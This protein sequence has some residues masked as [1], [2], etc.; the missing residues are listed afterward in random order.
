MTLKYYRNYDSVVYLDFSFHL[1]ANVDL[2]MT[3]VW[4]NPG[5]GPA[6][7]QDRT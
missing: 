2:G 7:R 4:K 3:L 1:L 6:D 5:Y